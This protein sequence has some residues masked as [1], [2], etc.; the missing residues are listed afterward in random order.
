M[1]N[2]TQN[3]IICILILV[4]IILGMY[5]FLIESR[6]DSDGANW[7]TCVPDS[8]TA[9]NIAQ[10]VCKSYTG[11]DVE[12]EAFIPEYDE[13]K[14]VWKVRIKSERDFDSTYNSWFE[15]DPAVYIEGNDATV[16]KMTINI[17]A[18]NHYYELKE[19]YK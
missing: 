9:V 1:K 19:Q 4:T 18:I 16:L 14:D 10:I 12:A 3:I 13:N 2:K 15:R 7:K 5:I 11:V 6:M 8:G 17:S